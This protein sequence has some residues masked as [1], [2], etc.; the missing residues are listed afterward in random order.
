MDAQ[1]FDR[2]EQEASR[3]LP[4]FHINRSLE[5]GRYRLEEVFIDIGRCDAVGR[6]FPSAEEVEA[7]LAAAQVVVADHRYE[8]FVDND[9][10]TI[11]IGL[12]Y[13]RNA[14][15]ETLYLDIIHELCHVRQHRQGRNLYDR[16]RPYVD[17]DTEI[18]AYEITVAEARR[19]GLGDRAIASYLC[20]SW[21]TPEEHRRLAARMGVDAAAA[22]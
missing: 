14:S 3:V 18:E 6:I 2:S 1:W 22:N 4:P 11:T 21:I 7:V 8:I 12:R 20:V 10:G 9:D 15:P 19:L 17:R 5:P 13:L 16:S